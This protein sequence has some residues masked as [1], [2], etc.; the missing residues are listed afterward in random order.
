[1][2]EEGLTHTGH[3]K[4]FI[5]KPSDINIDELIEALYQMQDCIYNE[6]ALKEAVI[7]LVCTYQPTTF[8]A[9]ILCS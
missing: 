7:N 8:D 6:K 5:G 4:I 1:M 2:N 9:S 3:K